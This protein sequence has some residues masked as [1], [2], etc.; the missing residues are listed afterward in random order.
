M[1][2]TEFLR[3]HWRWMTEMRKSVLIGLLTGLIV[4]FAAWWILEVRQYR[5]LNPS[6]QDYGDGMRTIAP[7]HH[8]RAVSTKESRSPVAAGIPG[9]QLR[10]ADQTGGFS[11]DREHDDRDGESGCDRRRDALGDGHLKSPRSG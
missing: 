1:P 6:P 9:L 8:P 11:G 3:A 2:L 5:Q 4:F 7:P 10:S